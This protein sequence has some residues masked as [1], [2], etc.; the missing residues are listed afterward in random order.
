MS[1]EKI[2]AYLGLI[3]DLDDKMV[4]VAG[5]ANKISA[6]AH[7]INSTSGKIPEEK[8]MA[9]AG[10]LHHFY[11][12]IEDILARIVKTVDGSSPGSGDWHSELLY[13]ATR[14]TP[15]LRPAIISAEMHEV[16]NEYKAFRHL[17]RH[18]YAKELRWRKM[19]HLALDINQVWSLFASSISELIVFLQKI[20]GELA[21][22]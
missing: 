1:R 18:A 3:G 6:L 7:E 20:I 16:L 5:I 2:N 22:E 4:S 17:F 14:K 8:L 11:G 10:Y 21:K 15:G 9:V 19:D 12:G 13:V